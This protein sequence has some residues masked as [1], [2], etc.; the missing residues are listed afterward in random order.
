MVYDDYYTNALNLKGPGGIYLY[1]TTYLNNQKIT[2]LAAGTV[3]SSSTDAVNGSQLYQVSSSVSTLSNT[4]NSYSTTISNISSTVNSMN[5]TVNNIVNGGGIKYFHAN[6]TLADSNASGSGSLAAGGAAVGSGQNA[7][8][9]GTGA[10]ASAYGD[11]AVGYWTHTAGTG[12]ATA[13]GDQSSALAGG[14]FAGGL[15]STASGTSAVALGYQSTSAGANS[16][17][18]GGNALANQAST[19]A[20]GVNSKAGGAGVADIGNV[21]IGGGAQAYMSTNQ[22]GAMP[23]V[24]LGYAAN[25]NGD[26]TWGANTVVG[27]YATASSYE[28][29][30]L[31]YATNASSNAVA[32]GYNS[33]ASG[34]SVAIGYV[35][36]TTGTSAIALGQSALASGN[37]AVATGTS[38]VASGG[39]SNAMGY[40]TNA[41]GQDSVAL[42][43]Q[44]NVGA[45]GVQGVAIG[46]RATATAA[47]SVALGTNSTTTANLSAAGYNP[48]TGALSGV[49]SAA[50]GEVSVGKAGAERRVTN[51]A[52][53]SAATDAVNVSQLQSED[54]KVNGISGNVSNLSNTVNNINA[55]TT[56]I[57]NTVTNIVN[58]GG[59]KYFHANSTLADSNASGSGSVAAG[60]AAVGSGSNATAVGT[61]ATASAA[62]AV[63]VG[64]NAQSAGAASIALGQSANVGAGASN[65]MALGYAATV[66]S[67]VASSGFAIGTG[68]Q[69]SANDGTALGRD[70]RVTATDSEALGH[71]ATASAANSVALG[72]YSTTTANLSAAGYNPGTGTLA[73]IASAANGEVS[74]GKAGAERRVT[75]V[76]AGSAATDAVNVSQLQSEDAK[77]NGISGNVSNL[78]NTV[79]NINASTTNINNTVT[80]IVNGGGIKY[81]H[82]NSTLA[83]SN[84]SGSG[85]VAAGGAAVGSGSNATA[86][87]TSATASAANAVAVGVN[88]QSAG[89]ASIALGQSANV[90]AG[91][92]NSMA[93]GYA[94]TVT[95]AV[96]SSGFAIGTGSQVSANDGT[97]LGRDTRVTATDSEALGHAAT[98]S[99]ANSVALG[100]Y[101]TTTATLSAAG[102]NP[103]TGTLA[104]IA[105]AANGEVSVGRAGAERR[106]TNVAAGSAATDAVNVSQL[107]SED[108]KVNGISGNVSNLSN[109]V[110]NINASTTNINN[111]VT[112]IVNGGGIKYFHA[113][114]S[115]ADSLASGANSVAVGDRANSMGGSSV[116]VGD[117]ATAVGAASVAIGNNAKNAATANNSVAIGGD[118]ASG[119]KSVTIGNGAN[120]TNSSW[121]VVVGTNA[122]VSGALGVA[123][124]GGSVASGANGVSMGP[125]AI[126]SGANTLALGNAANASAANSV[127]LGAG[128]LADRA[129]TVSV[130]SSTAQRQIINLSAGTANTDAVNVN[131]LKGVT[132]ALGGGAAVNADGSV[133]LPTYNVAGSTY[134]NVGDALATLVNGINPQLRYIQ[135][136]DTNANVAQASGSDSIAIGGNSFSNGNGAL[137]IG[138]GARAQGVNSV[139]IGFG[140]ATTAA[141]TFAVGSSTSTRRIV[142]VA[143]GVN[144][145]DAATVGQVSANIAAAM[146]NLNAG[147]KAQSQTTSQGGLPGAATSGGS[148]QMLGATSQSLLGVTSSLPPDQLLASGPTDKGGMIKAIGIDSMAIGLNTAAMADYAL[149]IG[150][151]VQVGSA[152]SVGVGQNIAINGSNTVVIGSVVSANAANA[153]VIGNNGTEADNDNAIAI[154]N[155]VAVGGS[156]TMA[157]GKDIVA[158]GVNSVTLG[159]ASS[160]NGR[161]NVLSVGSNKQQRQIIN[162]GAGTQNTDAV[163]VSQLSGAAAALGGGAALN[164]STGAFVAPK[165]TVQN[166]SNISDVGTAIAKLDAAET[167]TNGNVTNITSTVNNILIGGGIR[168]FHSNSALA[169]SVASGTDSVAIG[170]NATAT[171]ANSVALGANSVANSTTLASAAF[172]PTGYTAGSGVNN[173]G[174]VSVG[175]AGAQRRITNLAAGSASTDAVNVSQ[176]ATEDDKVNR[177]GAAAAAALGG[178]ATY[179]PGNDPMFKPSYAVGG[180]TYTNVGD[181][182]AA[183]NNAAAT[184]NP[185]GVAYDDTSKTQISLQGSGGTKLTKLKAGD[186]SATSTDAVNGAQLYATNQNVTN[187]GNNITYINNSINNIFNGE[188]IKYFHANSTLAD[189]AASGANAVAIGGNASA[190]TANSVALGAN[191]LANSSTLA[192]AAFNPGNATLSAATAAG[193]VSVGA[194]GS[195]R[196]ITNLA[197]GLNATDAVNVS[198]LKSEDA[199]VNAE[200][201]S[202]ASVIG[203]GST[204]DASTGK[205]TNPTYNIGGAT[206]TTIGGAI[207]NLDNRVYANS[208]DITNLQTQINDGG[209]GLVTQDPASKNILVASKTGGSTVDFTGTAGARRLTGVAAGT[210]SISSFDAVN[211]AQLFNVAAS[212]ASVIGGGSTYDASTGK[213]TNPTYNIGGATITTIGGAIT[214]LDNRVYANSTDIT[215]LQTQIND[216]GIGIVTQDATS[217]NILVASTTDGTIVDFTNTNG[218]ARKLTGVAA[219]AVNASSLDAVNGAQLF[220]VAAS[221]AS[222]IG[223]GSTY[224]PSTGRITNP[225][226]NIGGTTIT[227]IGGAIT[228]LD[229]RVYA[230][231]TDITNLQTQI[232]EGGIGIVTQDATSRNILVASKTDGTVVDFTNKDGAARVLTGVAAGTND[233]DAVNVAQLKAAGII[234][235][236]GSTKTAVTYDTT[237]DAS[238]KTATDYTNITLGDGSAGAAPVAIHNVAAGSSANDAVNFAQYTDLQAKVDKIANA[239]TGVDTL[240]VGDGDRNTEAAQVGGT[241]GV[242]MG[243]LSVANGLQSVATGYASNATGSNAVAIGAGSTASGNNSVALG[244]GSVATDDNTVSVGSASQQRRITN[245]AAGTQGTDAVNV[246]QLNDAIATAS[247]NTVNQAVQ[248]ANSYTDQQFNKMNDKMN[249]LGA[250][251]M[252]ATSLIPNARAEGNFQMS[253]AA[254]TYGGA[255]ALA[256]G[257][258]YWVSDR[259]LVNAH[260]TRSTGSGASTGASVGAT[261]GF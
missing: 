31:G 182:L 38:A 211:G 78:S 179:V 36:K 142:N 225:T 152:S 134:S 149:A 5:V 221:T 254:G 202:I 9:V 88:A 148:T 207:T 71:A 63:A 18:I 181:A 146:A 123:I 45:A 180:G 29:T 6:S 3:S 177:L 213:V 247:S 12:G 37:N 136:G 164:T 244:A 128:S 139:A 178:S 52:A 24:A 8:A 258:N 197:A 240:F 200:G 246:S 192:M 55:S 137:A 17:A 58:G 184:G 115:Q 70:T 108:A 33:T 209:I 187:L 245:V 133:K 21:A 203:G 89:A 229:A 230:N 155:N 154:G 232:N 227:T 49:A 188:G 168:Y 218:A 113:N 127:A 157:I 41:A 48:G 201:T 160:D 237:T 64:V 199:K 135:F 77:V 215:N 257:A 250:A 255:S 74:V 66:T 226:Y 7:T 82:A 140:S 19:I 83:D 243:A 2:S 165:Y 185:L 260:V 103:G 147:L 151:N 23:S 116:A 79:N 121:A 73:G 27:A 233:N 145:T 72:A 86:V 162:V 112:N 67:A 30:A 81:F 172:T 235:G 208:T 239:G 32:I 171:T 98:A 138:T 156:N 25:A 57:N 261:F 198:Q 76:A 104:G 191:S 122:N 125:N 43:T 118:S 65:S 183:L 175:A 97:A 166:L 75:N 96:A 234:N 219:G 241:H 143:D 87:G 217:R 216:G 214:N 92:S 39:Y 106:V 102:Y 28:A 130:G 223:G 46:A 16:L 26:N 144:A 129:N 195:E 170:G 131:Q 132:A 176:L 158:V 59:I 47:N 42:G 93:L 190:T 196:R 163:N 110:N 20:M 44:A 167:A 22:T 150:D 194:Q 259:L 50:N 40:Q 248:Q 256:V 224:D 205:V 68:S 61:S 153:I 193:E 220:N 124:G 186:V 4:V 15:S 107:Q 34:N 14:A 206:I 60:G 189:S 120:S 100:A 222:V 99:A 159:Y 204:Y 105:S 114:S 117:G 11:V 126:A 84:A 94:A 35:A 231:T 13:V 111:T 174:E 95:S 119:D 251:A 10:T 53:G 252:A 242:A 228:N 69:V 109:T 1:S 161:A 173:V 91:A 253:A 169:D 80:N 236:N 51:V 90:G 101:S 249:S 56:N 85:S 141:N 54:A 62:N 210:V 212:T 238:G